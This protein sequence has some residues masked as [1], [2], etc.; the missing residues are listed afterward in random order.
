MSSLPPFAFD[1]PSCGS[2]DGAGGTWLE[3]AGAGRVLA[4]AGIWLV[5][6]SVALGDVD[7]LALAAGM[8]DWLVDEGMFGSEPRPGG[9][10][11]L[12]TG[13]PCDAGFTARIDDCE[14]GPAGG[15]DACWPDGGCDAEA[16]S[17]GGTERGGAGI[18]ASLCGMGLG[19]TPI[20]VFFR[21]S[22]GFTFAATC[23]PEPGG[24]GGTADVFGELFFPRPSKMSR[25]ELP[26]L[27]S[28][29]IRVS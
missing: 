2:V 24:G 7:G 28:S 15:A 17:G 29:D 4:G 6:F 16:G 12:L 8:F 9:G 13:P 18:A 25:S 20:S 3:A 5:V 21:P 27:L 22:P 11:G 23:E 10:G 14:V 26:P 1:L 19:A